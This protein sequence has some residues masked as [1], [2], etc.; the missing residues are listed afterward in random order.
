MEPVV[1]IFESRAAAAQAAADLRSNG[2]P[3]PRIQMLLPIS[4]P[5]TDEEPPHEDAEQP[6]VG[7]ALGG[8]V[9]AATGASA[10]FGL[11][12]ITASFLIPGIGPVAAVGLAGAAIFGVVGA[13]GGATAAAAGEAASRTGIPKDELYLYED[14]L[15][16]GKGVV[17]ALVDSD[18][19]ADDVRQRLAR[20]GAESLDAAR[21]QWW[22]GIE[23]LGAQTGP[24][25]GRKTLEIAYRMGFFAALHPEIADQSYDA[26]LPRLR[27]KMGT[28][29]G[30]PAFRRGFERGSEEARRRQDAPPGNEA[31]RRAR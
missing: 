3:E 26:A 20:A 27:R 9:G 29:V 2:F 15:A 30:E 17:F 24:Q 11:G 8:V 12:A 7:R 18:A 28:L 13:I 31:G 6:G 4:D 5:A 23:Q 22:V 19:E 1:G 25:D 21:R 14:A 16:R 10:G